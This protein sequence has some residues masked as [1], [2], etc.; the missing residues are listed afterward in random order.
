MEASAQPLYQNEPARVVAAELPLY[1]NEEDTPPAPAAEPAAEQPNAPQAGAAVVVAELPLYENEKV[2]A[3]GL[4]T[5]ENETQSAPRTTKPP[6]EEQ[7]S[8]YSAFD[9]PPNTSD[10]RYDEQ[11]LYERIDDMPTRSYAAVKAAPQLVYENQDEHDRTNKAAVSA[12]PL[13]MYE[14]DDAKGPVSSASADNQYVPMAGPD[15]SLYANVGILTR[16]KSHKGSHPNV[17]AAPQEMYENDG[18]EQYAPP[19]APKVYV[20]SQLVY[21]NDDVTP[22][23]SKPTTKKASSSASSRSSFSVVNQKAE[24]SATELAALAEKRRASLAQQLET[25]V[26]KPESSSSAFADARQNLRRATAPATSVPVQETASAAEAAAAT[27]EEFG[28]GFDV[29][30]D[31]A[32]PS[33]SFLQ[34]LVKTKRKNLAAKQI[35][36][37]ADVRSAIQRERDLAEER[38]R[39]QEVTQQSTQKADVVKREAERKFAQEEQERQ[40]RQ[41]VEAEKAKKDKAEQLKKERELARLADLEEQRTLREFAERT[42]REREQQMQKAALDKGQKEV[43]QKRLEEEKRREDEK[44]K[45]EQEKEKKAKQPNQM[46]KSVRKRI[47]KSAGPIERKQ[48]TGPFADDKQ[49]FL[50][51]DRGEMFDVYKV[52]DDNTYF[53]KRC[54]NGEEGLLPTDVF[55]PFDSL[56]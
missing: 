30:G 13:P 54:S 40:Q 15:T 17:V 23:R 36:I 16:K 37:T 52:L 33:A 11:G 2:V 10:E 20:A 46:M 27:T 42:K 6:H 43:A 21:Q 8:V 53:V 3:G 39:L 41:K 14:N 26:S 50:K 34:D 28:F 56:Y 35:A 51:C 49:V 24:L 38:L 5:Y 4:P 9:A 25:P 44:R 55:L 48:T 47:F 12:A 18:A 29:F 22:S 31:V 32:Q 1:E 7:Q 19:V 45:R